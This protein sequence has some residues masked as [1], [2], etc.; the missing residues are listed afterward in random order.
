MKLSDECTIL[1]KYWSM[2]RL[3]CGEIFW[4]VIMHPVHFEMISSC[5]K[6]VQLVVMML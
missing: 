4:V 1:K 5:V 3:L 2:D 6:Y